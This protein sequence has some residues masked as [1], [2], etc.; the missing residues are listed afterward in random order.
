MIGAVSSRYAAALADV[1]LE[2]KSAD[3][4]KNDLA[5]FTEAYASSADLRNS[6]E[7]PSVGRE[8][9]L[10]VVQKIAAR[11]DLAPAVRNFLCVLVDNRRTEMLREIQQAFHVELNARLGIAEADVTSSRELSAEERKRLTAS[12]E[13]R[14]GKK[15]EARFHEDESLVGGAI[16]RVGSTVYDGSV[17]EQL[18]RLREQLEAE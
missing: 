5:A 17:R 12:L 8:A 9:K 16:V 2:Q 7:S 11:M 14:T 15:I 18:T 3:R 13:K 10:Q 4:V 6:L 1:A